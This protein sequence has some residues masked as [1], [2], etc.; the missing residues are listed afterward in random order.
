[1]LGISA[2][3]QHMLGHYGANNTERYYGHYDL[4]DLEQAMEQQFAKTRR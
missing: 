3:S 4:T 1:M 2:S